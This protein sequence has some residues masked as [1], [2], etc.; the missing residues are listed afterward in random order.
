MAQAEFDGE[1]GRKPHEGHKHESNLRK[2]DY[3]KENSQEKHYIGLCPLEIP[4]GTRS[5]PHA[6]VT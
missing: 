5:N 1:Q 6:R 3:N 4:F 2:R